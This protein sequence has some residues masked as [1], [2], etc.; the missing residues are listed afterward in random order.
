LLNTSDPENKFS[1]KG[2]MNR[3]TNKTTGAVVSFRPDENYRGRLMNAVEALG[4]ERAEVVK[5]AFVIGFEEAVKRLARRQK[6]EAQERIK[7]LSASFSQALG[8]SRE[9]PIAA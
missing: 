2:N 6:R 4:V 7:A 9:L 1:E 3:E 5:E 8:Q